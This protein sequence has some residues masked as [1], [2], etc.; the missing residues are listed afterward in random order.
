MYWASLILSL[1]FMHIYHFA[2][3]SWKLKLPHIKHNES[4]YDYPICCMG[5]SLCPVKSYWVVWSS[6]GVTLRCT[7]AGFL[8]DYGMTH[9]CLK[10]W[11]FAGGRGLFTVSPFPHVAEDNTYLK[12]ML[13]TSKFSIPSEVHKTN[14]QAHQLLWL[15]C[16]AIRCGLIMVCVYIPPQPL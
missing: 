2:C 13:L 16:I 10:Q 7:K 15:C 4:Y 9:S 5:G 3:H 6:K 1:T 8:S 11:S 14:F 12:G